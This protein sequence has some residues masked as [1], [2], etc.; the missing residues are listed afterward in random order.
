LRAPEL[1]PLT[2]RLLGG[3]VVWIATLYCG[4][5]KRSGRGRGREG[6][7]LYPELAVF[8]IREGSSP[9]LASQVGRL[10]ALLPSYELTRGEL[11]QRGVPLD[12]KVVHRLARQLG[13]EILTTRTRDLHRYRAGEL[14]PGRELAGKRVGVA[15]DGGRTRLRTVIRKQKGRGKAKKQRRRYRAE[16]REPKVLIIFEMD[17]RGRMVAGSRAWIDGT[18]AGPD[19]V[20]EL[21]AM[22]LHRLG[23]AE[24]AVV[25]FVADGAPWIWD[26]LEWVEKRVGLSPRRTVHVLDWCHA[27]HHVSLGLAALGLEAKERRRVYEQC[28]KWL[29]A[30]QVG[31]VLAELAV[32]GGDQPEDSPLETVLLYLEK[33]QSAGHLDY[34]RF[35]R[36]G[37][38]LGSGAIESAIR[39]VVNLR[40]KGAGLMWRKENAEA[41][42]VLRAAVLTE[43]WQETLEHVRATMASDRRLEWDW[44]SP[45]MP[46][47]LNAGLPI[48]PPSPQVAAEQPARSAAA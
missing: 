17:Q 7:G 26:R 12:I 15:I 35:R 21:L 11:A 14:P 41:Q 8:G 2:L 40:L 38:A 44:E 46:A 48:A 1:R 4:P 28:K 5:A 27:L 31:R 10:S 23:A 9:A 30:G 39:R 25:T 33:H 42:L 24:A 32:R 6:A 43:R 22:H 47:E 13:A 19:E 29:R 37:L 18:F 45:D 3:L 34:D 20:M 36:R 16:W